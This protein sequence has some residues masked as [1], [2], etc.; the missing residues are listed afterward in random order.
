ML[1]ND[2]DMLLFSVEDPRPRIHLDEVIE[3]NGARYRLCAII[4]K[5]GRHYT[6][7]VH[8]DSTW[9]KFN[10]D[11]TKPLR[12]CDNRYVRALFY[13]KLPPTHTDTTS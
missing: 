12:G 6:A 9:T 11:H 8:T 7:S 13:K 10:D 1:I 3:I 4:H 5:P 2:S